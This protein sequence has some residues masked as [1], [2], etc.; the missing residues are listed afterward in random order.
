TEVGAQV[1]NVTLGDRVG[2]ALGPLGSYSSGRLYPA[3]RLV[4]LPDTIS[5]EDAAATIF[6]GI[7]AQYLIKSTYTVGSGTVVL[8]YGAA[9]ALG[10]ILA[11]WAKHLG[12]FVIGVVSKDAR[13]DR[14]RAA[15]CDAVLVWG[16]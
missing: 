1:T 2:Y 10:Q 8:L 6:K 4:K 3:D 11:P 16:A 7:A 5:F 15:G 12:A 13:V 9:G 14:A